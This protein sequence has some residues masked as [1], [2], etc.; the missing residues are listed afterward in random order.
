MGSSPLEVIGNIYSCD[1]TCKQLF[2][3]VLK[4][5]MAHCFSYN[6]HFCFKPWNNCVCYC[7]VRKAHLQFCH[8][9]F[10]DEMSTCEDDLEAIIPLGF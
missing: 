8:Q 3:K 1:P 4:Q 2:D 5:M 7:K 10:H 6:C 9:I